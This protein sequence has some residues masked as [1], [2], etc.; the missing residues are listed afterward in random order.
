[1]DLAK[2]A[3]RGLFAEPSLV[4]VD[5]GSMPSPKE[6]YLGAEPKGDEHVEIRSNNQ[7]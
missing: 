1:V 4:R 7:Y 2:D 6:S 5:C 3:K